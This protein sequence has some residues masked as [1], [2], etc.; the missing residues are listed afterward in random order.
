MANTWKVHF[1][2]WDISDLIEMLIFWVCPREI[3]IKSS[4]W[5]TNH[6]YKIDL[7]MLMCRIDTVYQLLVHHFSS[8]R[9]WHQKSAFLMKNSIYFRSFRMKYTLSLFEIFQISIW[10]VSFLILY[11][12]Y[13]KSS[14][15]LSNQYLLYD[16]PFHEYVQ[17]TYQ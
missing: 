10:Y 16:R 5:T 11:A 12:R 2:C 8:R 7:N 9:R 13:I 6:Y 15:W 4:D 17:N 3:S 14:K 1:F